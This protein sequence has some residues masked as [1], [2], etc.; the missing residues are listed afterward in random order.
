MAQHRASGSSSTSSPH[1]SS[2]WDSVGG[3][4]GIL[5][6]PTPQAAFGASPSTAIRDEDDDTSERAAMLVEL[7]RIVGS[8]NEILEE[9]AAAA[10]AC[11]GIPPPAAASDGGVDG[12][13][14]PASVSRRR[15]GSS[16][17]PWRTS[18]PPLAQSRSSRLTDRQRAVLAMLDEGAG[19]GAHRRPSPHR[20]AATEAASRPNESSYD[21]PTALDGARLR[22]L[23]PLLDRLGRTLTDAAPHIAALAD[24]LPLSTTPSQ[25]RPTLSHENNISDATSNRRGS[26]TAVDADAATA[27][28][29]SSPEEGEDTIQSLTAR[30]AQLYF[31]IGN[32]NDEEDGDG[33]TGNLMT[34]L[35]TAVPASPSSTAP[36]A[37]VLEV[38]YEEMTS[39]IDPDL[40]DYV[41]GM[42]N[43]TRGGNG[44]FGSGRNSS[45]MDS[46]G[47]SLLASYLA[48]MGGTP[49]GDGGM[50]E[51]R[52]GGNANGRD[53]ARVIRMGGG[54][55]GNGGSSAFGGGGP[56]ID[57][58]IH[59]IVTG[60][61]MGGIGGL[62]G[63]AM[64]N[65]GGIGG[66]GAT[67]MA[68]PRNNDS[69][70]FAR[71]SSPPWNIN[72][73]DD[74]ADLF[75]ELYS[76]S[77][78]PVNLHGEEDTRVNGIRVND[79][80]RLFDECRS[81]D[82]YDSDD[83]KDSEN[84][85][86]ADDQATKSNPCDSVSHESFI[87]QNANDNH[88]ADVSIDSL[89]EIESQESTAT[90]PPP[91]SPSSSAAFRVPVRIGSI[92]RNSSPAPGSSPSLGSRLFR[93]TFGRLP[94]SSSRRSG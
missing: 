52:N 27:A 59:A 44:G 17:S 58:H 11:R 40:T 81:I 38:A 25:P 23:A 55:G 86:E 42:V 22:Q 30:A 60:P 82:D 68:T 54:M 83:S 67:T 85:D 36:L 39:L 88:N 57:I 32:D 14:P 10:G 50:R 89:S 49:G 48:S 20:S 77:P 35:T 69:P 66:G 19:G 78:D 16:Q 9:A 24:S 61:G 94:G 84:E 45:G 70:F 71:E 21:P 90:L 56:G 26:A 65:T 29:P 62:G 2:A 31:G 28:G 6:C 15:S 92:G 47:S 18:P 63:F 46:L 1:R 64:D 33:P 51:G 41:N 75:S 87:T 12:A 13:C 53:N 73:D 34:A 43:T 3:G 76:E 7:A 93:R 91:S 74:D 8:V 72:R 80:D 79:L 5:A 37:D 4:G